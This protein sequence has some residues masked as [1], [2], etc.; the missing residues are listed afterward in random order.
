MALICDIDLDS[1][2]NIKDAYIRIVRFS[3][4][5][6]SLNFDVNIYV[7]KGGYDQGKST[8][9]TISHIMDYDKDQNIFRQMYEHLRSLP[10][11]ENAVEA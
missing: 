7:S 2:L 1:G 8:V 6:N 5:E 3:G 10:E 9:A 4:T 11:Y